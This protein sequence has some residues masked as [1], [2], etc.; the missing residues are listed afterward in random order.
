ML[1]TLKDYLFD[2]IGVKPSPLESAEYHSILENALILPKKNHLPVHNKHGFF[3]LAQDL[4]YSDF[5][6]ALTDQIILNKINNALTAGLGQRFREYM[7]QSMDSSQKSDDIASSGQVIQGPQINVQLRFLVECAAWERLYTQM[8]PIEMAKM[9]LQCQCFFPLS[10]GPIFQIFGTPKHTQV[11]DRYFLERWMKNFDKNWATGCS[12][13]SKS[14]APKLRRKHVFIGPG[15]MFNKRLDSVAV[16][17]LVRA[18]S[19]MVQ[20]VFGL[21]KDYATKKRVRMRYSKVYKMFQELQENFERERRVIPSLLDAHCEKGKVA[22]GSSVIAFVISFVCRVFPVSLFGDVEN[23][24]RI[25]QHLGTFIYTGRKLEVPVE[26]LSEGVKLNKVPW[27][28]KGGNKDAAEQNR[29]IFLCFLRWFYGDYVVGFVAAFFHVTN[30]AN[31]GAQLLFFRHSD[32]SKSAQEYLTSYAHKYLCSARAVAVGKVGLF[33]KGDTGMRMLCFPEK[34]R[35]GMTKYIRSICIEIRRLA[36]ER[37]MPRMVAS[38]PD[39]VYTILSFMNGKKDKNIYYMKFDV[40]ACYDVLPQKKILEIIDELIDPTDVFVVDTESE[41][42]RLVKLG[43]G[44]WSLYKQLILKSV[45]EKSPSRILLGPARVTLDQVK[46]APKSLKDSRYTIRKSDL[47][48]KDKKID[49]D[50]SKVTLNTALPQYRVFRK[51]EIVDAV[52]K[53][54][55]ESAIKITLPGQRAEI[56]KRKKGIFQG[57]NLLA[58]FC[59]LF[60][61]YVMF[62]EANLSYDRQHTLVVRYADDFLVL[63]ES[64]DDVKTIYRSISDALLQHDILINEEKSESNFKGNIDRNITFCGLRIDTETWG[65]VKEYRMPAPLA[66]TAPKKIYN[67]GL[68]HYEMKMENSLLLFSSN[69]VS[70]IQRNVM[71]HIK[72]IASYISLSLKKMPYLSFDSQQF[73]KYFMKFQR[74]TFTR[75]AKLNPARRKECFRIS[76][77]HVAMGFL[78]AGGFEPCKDWL[79]KLAEGE[80][81][82][83]T[84]KGLRRGTKVLKN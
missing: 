36:F 67:H 78:R 65:I 6:V 63:S 43:R 31:N 27:L 13:T 51:S 14:M 57:L 25:F 15:N 84:I 48:E 47:I 40:S 10:E 79:E 1:I 58:I 83:E 82:I 30:T 9:I 39:V 19:Q 62:K 33:P 66:C 64:S 11:N 28:L 74:L 61:D 42:A 45:K 44:K 26:R 7:T 69:T 38:V 54:L 37:Y 24:R 8:G 41:K 73:Q 16:T 32:W 20:L 55:F 59:D 29:E 46:Q 68:W 72:A 2:Q 70:S 18:P 3:Q 75:L 77:R 76:L 50:L 71:E 56:F 22:K 34:E 35:L 80:T 17:N 5:L 12:R 49:F 4:S 21:E 60:F 81:D 52:S 23:R 53:Q